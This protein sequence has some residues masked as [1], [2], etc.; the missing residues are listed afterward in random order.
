MLNLQEPRPGYWY[1]NRA[2]KLMK[3]KMVMHGMNGIE[4]VLIQYVEGITHAIN[5][6]AWQCLDLVSPRYEQGDV[7]LESD[8]GL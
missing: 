6:D 3:V 2:G 4:S 8:S 7:I 1:I 5:I